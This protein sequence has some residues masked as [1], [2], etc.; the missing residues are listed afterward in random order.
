[1]SD[2][3]QAARDQTAYQLNISESDASALK[4]QGEDSAKRRGK[5]IGPTQLKFP[6][7]N[8]E[9]TMKR[10]GEE[11]LERRKHATENIANSYRDSSS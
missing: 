2:S 8:E 11:S 3:K 5:T 6:N 9:S 10:A 7:D 1:M 4:T